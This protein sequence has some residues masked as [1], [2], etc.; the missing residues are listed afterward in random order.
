MLVLA[1]TGDS[2]FLAPEKSAFWQGGEEAPLRKKEM[3]KSA[4]TSFL[5]K[6]L[7]DGRQT[8]VLPTS[9]CQVSL[10]RPPHLQDPA[11]H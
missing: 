4:I 9:P 3:S 11:P 5:P 2:L 10:G 6:V 1:W 8:N 7:S